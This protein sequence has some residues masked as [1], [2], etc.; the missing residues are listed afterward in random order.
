M[1]CFNDTCWIF[2]LSLTFYRRRRHNENWRENF[3]WLRSSSLA[4]K[5]EREEKSE[6]AVDRTDAAKPL[7]GDGK[8]ERK[9]YDH[10]ERMR[11]TNVRLNFMQAALASKERKWK[12]NATYSSLSLALFRDK[13]HFFPLAGRRR[14]KN[15]FS[16]CPKLLHCC[17][18]IA[19]WISGE[20]AREFL[21]FFPL[22]CAYSLARSINKNSK[23]PRN[24]HEMSSLKCK[25]QNWVGKSC[26]SRFNLT[27]TC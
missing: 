26:C 5:G 7:K 25:C 11:E 21:F 17:R 18:S 24:N 20:E 14:E 22:V 12:C 19:F 4:G 6:R 1:V 10:L 2:S 23:T 16:R 3:V 9:K 15:H 8:K 13:V 27:T